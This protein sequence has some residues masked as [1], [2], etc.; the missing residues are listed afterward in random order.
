MHWAAYVKR[1]R[2]VEVDLV[3]GV[4]VLLRVFQR[5]IQRHALLVQSEVVQ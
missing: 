5:L 2:I 3:I 1:E 4:E